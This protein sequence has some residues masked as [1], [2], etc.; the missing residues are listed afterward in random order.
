[1]LIYCLAAMKQSDA[2][3]FEDWLSRHRNRL[4]P[5]GSLAWDVSIDGD[6]PAGAGI[7]YYRSHIQRC[8]TW[9]APLKAFNGAWRAYRAFLRRKG[10]TA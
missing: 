8:T 9:D 6:W 4:S 5:L 3:T 7:E 10:P 2:I 1:M